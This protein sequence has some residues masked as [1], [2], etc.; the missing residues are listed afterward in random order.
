MCV[1]GPIGTKLSR[2]SCMAFYYFLMPA[3]QDGDTHLPGQT[4]KYPAPLERLADLGRLW[5]RT[6]NLEHLKILLF[7]KLRQGLG[8]LVHGCQI[9]NP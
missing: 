3:R 9:D 7:K 4:E 1:A 6:V 2:L 8:V 5:S